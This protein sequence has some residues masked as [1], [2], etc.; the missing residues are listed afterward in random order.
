MFRVNAV[1]RESRV[2][3]LDVGERLEVRCS[4]AVGRVPINAVRLGERKGGLVEVDF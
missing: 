2:E 1:V 4:Q 3:V